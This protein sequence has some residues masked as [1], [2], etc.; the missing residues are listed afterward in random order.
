MNK[1]KLQFN[2]H[3]GS[4]DPG[5]TLLESH[6]QFAVQ[7]HMYLDC[8]LSGVCIHLPSVLAS[9]HKHF[10]CNRLSLTHGPALK[11]EHVDAI[12]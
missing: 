3:L 8:A 2:S 1:Y 9:L 10:A 4:S 5:A 12:V 7:A 11:H 6:C